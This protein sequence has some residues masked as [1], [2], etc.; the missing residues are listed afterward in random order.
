MNMD[1]LLS[2]V[3]VV[4]VNKD[5]NAATDVHKLAKDLQATYRQ[6]SLRELITL[7]ELSIIEIGGAAQ[8][9]DSEPFCRSPPHAGSA[10]LQNTWSHSRT[11]V[12]A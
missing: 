6:C 3:A 8:W 12:S 10:A 7:I 9:D 2:I 11:R 1:A 5:S 4:T